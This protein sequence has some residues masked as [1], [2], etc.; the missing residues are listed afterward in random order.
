MALSDYLPKSLIHRIRT[1]IGRKILPP[2]TSKQDLIEVVRVAGRNKLISP[3]V[4]SIIERV[5][6][7]SDLQVRDVMIPRLSMITIDLEFSLD[8]IL[9]IVTESGHSRFP[10]FSESSDHDAKGILLAKDILHHHSQNGDQEFNLFDSIRQPVFVPESMRLDTLL[11]RFQETRSHMAI[12]MNEYKGIHGLVTIEDVLE[13]IVGEIEDESDF[14]ADD[15]IT[16]SSEHVFMVNAQTEIKEFNSYFNSK[17][18]EDV[19]TIGGAILKIAGKVP[20]VGDQFEHHGFTFG[21]ATADERRLLSLR[22]NPPTDQSKNT[23]A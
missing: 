6:C 5:V 12:V 19:D 17:L 8:E 7:S 21:V 20:N 15:M 13:E 2:P 1:A 16:K 14:M 4:Q 18:D 23:S 9:K 10:V 3:S 22:V 11:K